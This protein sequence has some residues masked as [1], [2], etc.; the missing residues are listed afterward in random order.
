M[1]IQKRR[2]LDGKIVYQARDR[3]PG[4]PSLSRTFYKV[5]DAKKWFAKIHA[6]RQ[7][8]VNNAALQRIT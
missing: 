6:E 1:S 4:F 7:R 3:S 8:G 2:L 5:S